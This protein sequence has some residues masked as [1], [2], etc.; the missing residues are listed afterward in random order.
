MDFYID[1]ADENQACGW[2]R[3]PSLPPDE[4]LSLEVLVNGRPIGM[5]VADRF[6]QDLLDGGIGDGRF[7]YEFPFKT[8]PLTRGDFLAF[9]DPRTGKILLE[10]TQGRFG[11]APTRLGS[12]A[13]RRSAAKELPAVVH[14]G[15]PKTGTTFLQA[16][17]SAN[18]AR[19][20]R[21]GIYVVETVLDSHRLAIASAPGVH[22]PD[23]TDIEAISALPV[24]DVF[25]RFDYAAQR[26]GRCLISSEY[27][28]NA[29]PALF[30]A[31]L[32]GHK[33]RVEK[34]VALTRRQNRLVSSG[35]AQV[36]KVLGKSAPLTNVAYTEELDFDLL[37]RRWSAAFPDA[38]LIFRDFD[39]VCREGPLEKFFFET[40]L[41]IP[42]DTLVRDASIGEARNES[43]GARLLELMRLLNLRGG[44]DAAPLLMKA[45]ADGFDPTRFA[46][47]PE[48]IDECF[49]A[50]LESNR[51]FIARVRLS[52]FAPLLD[53]G[54][55]LADKGEDY[56][57]R[58]T[59]EF[60]L[61][62]LAHCAQKG[63]LK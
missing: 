31:M 51:R 19:L 12:A 57:D 39:A 43:L 62:F 21:S 48:R 10:V 16:L 60:V 27:F 22:P 40:A 55:W 24:T 47:P 63:Y 5:C 4:R 34:I 49:D 13:S 15:P 61:D 11:P 41:G 26:A 18:R 35:H 46:M 28:V 25:E 23:R 8:R 3:D 59:L 54:A 14:V 1:T 30:R 50:F 56:T 52:E 2:A 6:R 20:E 44:G 29:D 7:A 17:M 33:C 36:T 9:R 45:Q 38:E 32:A 37:H 42:A 58:L 53:R